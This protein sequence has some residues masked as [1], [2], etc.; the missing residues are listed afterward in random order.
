MES[1]GRAKFFDRLGGV[2]AARQKSEELS[3]AIG[4]VTDAQAPAGDWWRAS[5]LEGMGSGSGFNRCVVI[6]Q[7]G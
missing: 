4:A 7:R 5:L 3:K 2:I 6:G 1:A